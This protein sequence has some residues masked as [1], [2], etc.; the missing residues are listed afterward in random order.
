M[1]S[2]TSFYDFKPVDSKFSHS[3]RNTLASTLMF[4]NMAIVLA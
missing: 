2:A 1:A 4:P 3:T